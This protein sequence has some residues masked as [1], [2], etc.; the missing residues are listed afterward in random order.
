VPTYRSQFQ[1]VEELLG[2]PID[3]NLSEE[4]LQRLVDQGVIEGDDLEFK[5]RYEKT[6]E[7]RAEIAKDI[8]ALANHR[9]GVLILGVAENAGRA[10]RLI[11]RDDFGDPEIRRIRSVLAGRVHPGVPIETIS[12]PSTNEPGKEYLVLL[13]PRSAS[14]PHAVANPSGPDLRYWVRQ[15]SQ[16]MALGESEVADRYRDRFAAARSRVDRLD[17]LMDEGDVR[18]HGE[19]AY[20][21]VGVVPEAAG[22]MA[23][24]A[25]AVR[26][27]EEWARR[28]RDHGSLP[29]LDHRNSPGIERGGEL[30]RV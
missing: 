27:L 25:P 11:P 10:S 5:L 21:A 13:V 1:R 4:D 17:Q 16:T 20:L 18:L 30:V 8:A 6:E 23:L 9:G 14:A 3:N 19:P 29:R 12:V 2:A 15:G 24:D 26:Q 28:G 7:H 22:R